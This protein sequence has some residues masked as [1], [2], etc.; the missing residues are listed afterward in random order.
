M[1]NWVPVVMNLTTSSSWS[2]PRLAL[3]NDGAPVAA[4][5]DTSNGVRIGVAR[6]TGTSWDTRFGTFNAGQNPL[7]NIVPELAV[8]AKGKIWVAWQEG[9][10]AQVWMSNY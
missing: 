10:A 1:L 8:D 4:W 3:G 6:W 7:N 2:A 5:L 9:P